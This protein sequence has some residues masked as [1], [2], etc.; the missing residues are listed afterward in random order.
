MVNAKILDT[1]V[2]LGGIYSL[3][4]IFII[5]GYVSGKC[6]R[7]VT[8][9]M[10][11]KVKECSAMSLCAVMLPEVTLMWLLKSSETMR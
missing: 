1:F 6:W 8:L 2:S 5:Q 4:F 7:N 9:C 11:I 3:V 10:L